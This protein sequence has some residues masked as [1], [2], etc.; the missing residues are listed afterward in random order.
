MSRKKTAKARAAT[1]AH[2]ER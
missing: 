2:R 1:V